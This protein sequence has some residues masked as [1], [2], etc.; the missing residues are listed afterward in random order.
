M[1]EPRKD[2]MKGNAASTAKLE[3]ALAVFGGVVVLEEAFQP[4]G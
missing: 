1:P 3:E 4:S 2:Q